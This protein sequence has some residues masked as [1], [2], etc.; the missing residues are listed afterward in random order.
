MQ[1]GRLEPL[2]DAAIREH[3]FSGVIEIRRGGDV[4]FA[5]AAGH[6]DRSNRIP[7]AL[8][9]RFGIA[10]GTKFLTALA[11]GKLVDAGRISLSTRLADCLALDVRGHSPEI[12]LRHLLTHTSGIP[13]Y[14]DES[15]VADFDDFRLSVPW[16]DLRGPRDYLPCFPDEEAK[17]AP[18]E[19]FAYSNGGY[20]LL[21]VVIEELTGM[22]YRD[23]VTRS[24]FEP[25][26]MRR[27]G[28]FALNRLPEDTALGYVEEPGGWRTNVYDLP[29]VGASDGGAFTTLEDVGKLWA[30][31][32]GNAIL[33]REL[34]EVFTAPFVRAAAKRAETYSGH[35]IWIRRYADGRREFFL[36]GCDAGVS[37]ETSVDREAGLRVTVMSNT[38]RGAW[39]ILEAA[40]AALHGS[41]AEG[42]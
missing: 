30:A 14:F 32:W 28:Y 1:E 17:F 13:D 39:P 16:H 6:A 2:L 23:F 19:G 10:S 26:G 4:L 38:T 15:R 20:I 40:R 5:R 31:F 8:T 21:G 22:Q 35:G 37:V 25:L 18:G 36:P 7:N 34:V 24:I 27:S 12:T 42:A 3:A 33:S 41:S 29:I 11:V 9:T